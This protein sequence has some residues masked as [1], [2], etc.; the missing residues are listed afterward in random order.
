MLTNT[1]PLFDYAIKNKR[2][3]CAFNISN[4][5]T[6]QAVIEA[7]NEL[8]APIIISASESAI[9]YAGAKTLVSIVNSLNTSKTPIALHLDHGKSY[10]MCK[11][12][13]EAG[14][15]SVMFDG[16]DLPFEEN[17]KTTKRIVTV[18]HKH[19]VTVEAEL[20]RIVGIEDNIY[21]ADSVLTKPE[22]AVLFVQKTGCD[23]L[24][25]S[26]GTA[27][28]I[29]KGSKEPK[30][31]YETIENVSRALGKNYPLVAHGSSSVPQKF[32]ENINKFGGC[33]KKS[34]GIS[35]KDLEKMSK[36]SIC[37]INI[38]TDLRLAFTSAV[39]EFLSQNL[40]VFDPRK[41]LGY[42]K[43]KMKEHAKEMIKLITL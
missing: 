36:T 13:I 40:E 34:Q 33:I 41:I 27:H 15:S 29:N 6:A 14:F 28:G 25:I 21:S 12:C 3:I 23:S 39:R 22:E 24:A 19:G 4:L 11:K 7:S 38:D 35:P 37:K 20:G 9:A 17:V 10:E 5:E 8:G 42:A 16:S 1:K 31:H 18:A 30:I 26:I 43:N 2:A 32:V